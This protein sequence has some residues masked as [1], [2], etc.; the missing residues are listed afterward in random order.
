MRIMNYWEALIVGLFLSST[1]VA[2]SFPQLYENR[3]SSENY[4]ITKLIDG[5]IDSLYKN[6]KTSEYIAQSHSRLWKINAKGQIIDYLS[7]NTFYASGLILED[8]GFSDWVF[9]GDKNIKP[10]GKT[11]D[12]K[13]YSDQELFAAFDQA[14]A[15]EFVDK[16]ETGFAYLYQQGQVSVLDISNRRDQIDDFYFRQSVSKDYNL[17]REE[18]DVN[19][20]RFEKYERKNV[21]FEALSSSN[22]DTINNLKSIGFKKVAT[23]R[24]TK[25]IETFFENLLGI[26][27]SVGSRHDYGYDVG[28]DQYQ[29]SHHKEQLQFS[30]FSDREYD[31]VAAWNFKLI[32]D[33]AKSADDLLFMAVNYRRHY[34]AELNEQS[35]LPYYEKDV[36]LYVVRKIIPH[37]QNQNPQWQ[38]SYSGLH[39]NDSISGHI[40]FTETLAPVFYWFRQE[41]PIPAEAKAD[42]DVF[43]RRANIASPLLKTLPSS[44]YFQWEDFK[45][46]RNFRLV[47]NHQ[48]AEFYK[49][50]DTKVV[51]RLYFDTQELKQAFAQFTDVKDTIELNLDLQERTFGGELIISVT[52]GKKAIV[53][54]NTSFDYQEISYAPKSPQIKPGKIQTEL[55]LAYEESL[56]KYNPDK[57]L[58]KLKQLE[59]LNAIADYAAPLSYYFANLSLT[60]NAKGRFP[61]NTKLFTQYFL[62]HQDITHQ[63][64]E[65]Q[66]KNLMVLA[67]QGL[68]LGSNSMNPSL[69][70]KVIATFVDQHFD[71]EK[72]TNRVF[73]FNIACYFAVQHNKPE[74]LRMINRAIALG[75]N[76][77][78]FFK[79]NDFKDYW[80]DMDFLKA[81]QKDRSQ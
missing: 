8:D 30:V 79:D 28:Y 75:K 3:A 27:F 22:T 19:A 23:H 25:I 46:D 5:P 56:L 33:Q 60:L 10:Y 11:V 17:R 54:K 39:S 24:P 14:D 57:F 40:Q 78:N 48:D 73:I 15:I 67:S 13:K 72:E 4:E 41:R 59:Q 2:K 50:E 21:Q 53:L 35:L 43:G 26:I 38:L 37:N 58:E 29:L 70:K 16:D 42:L 32:N 80:Q 49:P 7:P 18:T 69:N 55:F 45:R 76:P 64:D 34:L 68:Y 65:L 74:M 61:E 44:L 51:I 31:S 52:N 81:I 47:I 36:G 9:T 20:S 1:A 12:A 66:R 71:L 77:D 63:V 6:I 62:I